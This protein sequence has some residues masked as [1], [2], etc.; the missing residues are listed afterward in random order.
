MSEATIDVRSIIDFGF[1]LP[2]RAWS[3]CSCRIN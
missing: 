1:E 3:W 2:S